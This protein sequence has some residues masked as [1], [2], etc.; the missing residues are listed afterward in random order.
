[1][2]YVVSRSM[3][4]A[5]SLS[6]TCMASRA[7]HVEIVTSLT[8]KD[9]LLAFSRFNDVRGKVEV[10]YLDNGTT[11]QAAA[12]SLPKLLHTTELRNASRKKG[13]LWQ[14]IPPYAPSQGGAWESMEKRFK[15][16]L[17]RILGSSKHIPNLM[18]LITFCSNS[19]RVVNER[20][21]TA[22]SSDPRDNTVL[23]PASLLTPGL[24][25]YT[26]VGRAH[27]KDK[28][29]RHYRFNLAL[30]T[31]F[32]MIGW[33]FTWLLYRV[34]ISGGKLL[35][36]SNLGSWFWLVTRRTC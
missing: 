17:Q 18:E 24:Y 5:W 36:T 14:F 11:F 30:Q 13:V 19:V 6:F 8:L 33:I 28:L 12:K 1:M 29:R 21:L 23:T 3:R 27:D 34:E 22:V 35:E 7:V 9:F 26:P 31:V 4:K 20:P 10:I 16:I 15:L 2:S 32:G 25:P